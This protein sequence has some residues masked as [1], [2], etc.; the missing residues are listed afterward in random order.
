[1]DLLHESFV[2]SN[3]L[4]VMWGMTFGLGLTLFAS[5]LV[6]HV[7]GAKWEDAIP[8]MQAFGVAVAINQIG[9]NW[10]AYMRARN[11]TRGLAV[12]GVGS[13]I[14]SLVFVIP[15]LVIWGI[16]GYAVGEIARVLIM[17]A[18]R[19]HYLRVMFRGF[20]LA[21]YMVR[22]ILPSLPAVGLVLALRIPESGPRSLELAIGE[23]TLYVLVTAAATWLL[24]RDLLREFGR[25]LRG[26]GG[27]RAAAPA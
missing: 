8:I 15:P 9:F 19:G 17:L 7:L 12:V 23:L 6:H 2:K 10:S 11:D 16:E 25:Y 27:R 26:V 4:G 14:G 21:K 5:D 24:E 18:L 20:S 1:M 13:L 22:A 3:R